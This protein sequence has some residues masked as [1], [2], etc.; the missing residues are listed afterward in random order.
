MDGRILMGTEVETGNPF[1]LEAELFE[2][3][4]LHSQGGTGQGKSIHYAGTLAQLVALG[5]SV[6]LTIDIAS[7]PEFRAMHRLLARKNGRT[8]REFVLGES[9]KFL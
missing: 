5:N 9:L 2:R 1:Y 3:S 6:T 8:Y 7:D 4:H